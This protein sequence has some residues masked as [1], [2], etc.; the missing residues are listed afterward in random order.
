MTLEQRNSRGVQREVRWESGAV[1]EDAGG[2]PSSE[3]RGRGLGGHSWAGPAGPT[4]PQV[5]VPSPTLPGGWD[6]PSMVSSPEWWWPLP[7]GYS[8]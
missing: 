2:E 5:E 8:G 1:R 4:P 7:H 6:M 3:A